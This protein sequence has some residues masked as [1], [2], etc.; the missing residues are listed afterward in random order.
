[1]DSILLM[2]R[3]WVGSLVGKLISCVSYSMTKINQS[4]HGGQD[5]VYLPC[6]PYREYFLV[7]DGQMLNNYLR[8]GMSDSEF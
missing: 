6:V 3:A 4:I 7:L 8:E 5:G 1:M 2:Q